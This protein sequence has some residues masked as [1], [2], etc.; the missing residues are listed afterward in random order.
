M[1]RTLVFLISA[2]A[3]AAQ[4]R[5]PATPAAPKPAAPKPAATKPAAPAPARAGAVPSYK[6]LKFPTLRPIQVPKIDTSTLPNGIRLYLLEDHELP[7]VNGTALVRTGNLFDPR[8]KVGVALLAGMVMRTGGTKAKTG[9]ELNEQL[10]NIAASV[11]TAIDESFGSVTFSALKPNAAE[12]LAVFKDVLSSPEFRQDKLDLAKNQLRSVIS[13][14][15][16]NPGG[17]AQREFQD[18]VYGKETPYGW[19]EEYATLDRIGRE[20]LLGFYR[21]YFFQKNLVLAV[22]GDFDTAE[23]KPQIEKAFSDWTV[24]QPPVPD[25]PKVG[26]EPKG[27]T[28]LAVKNDVTQTFFAIGQRGGEIRDKD[29]PA[30]AIMAN[31]LGGGFQSRLFRKVR[32]EMGNAYEIGATWSARYDH[33][34][35]FEISGSTKSLSTVDTIK[36]I[37]EEVDRIRTTEV[38]EAELKTA[39][40]TALNSFVFAFDTRAKTLG[41]LLSYEY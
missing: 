19:E 29:Y 28:L 35:V 6:D 24:T 27:A 22:S 23:M 38:T 2:A 26:P 31:I 7:L 41:R 3:L 14:R 13:R 9:D 34:G 33:P 4:T 36:A 32:T 10:E 17:I 30:L 1:N 25:F 12:V 15:N 18:T 5:P 20:D 11:E 8:E 16:D 37:R 39:K 40:D 21:R